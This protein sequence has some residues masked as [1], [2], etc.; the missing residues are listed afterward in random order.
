[1]SRA[2]LPVI[3]VFS[4]LLMLSASIQAQSLLYLDINESD[5]GS[6]APGGVFFLWDPEFLEFW[7][8][9]SSGTV[10]TQLWQNGAVA[11]FGAGSDCWGVQTEIASNFSPPT[12]GGIR[13][14]DC[15]VTISNNR[16]VLVGSSN[17]LYT[18][19]SRELDVRSQ[20]DWPPNGAIRKT[21]PGLLEFTGATGDGGTSLSTNFDLEEGTLRLASS[22]STNWFGGESSADLSI[23]TGSTSASLNLGSADQL[24]NSTVIDLIDGTF[25]LQGNDETIRGLTGSGLVT[26]GGIL[27]ISTNPSTYAF[28]G[29]ITD[30]ATPTNLTI[31]GAGEQRFNGVLSHSGGTNV[32]G[33]GR[34]AVAGS[35]TTSAIVVEDGELASFNA[36]LQDV[37]ILPSGTLK[38]GIG[39]TTA[40]GLSWEDGG[41]VAWELGPTATNSDSSNLVVTDL[42]SISDGSLT[43]RINATSDVPPLAQSY[44]LILFSS[45]NNTTASHYTVDDGGLLDGRDVSIRIESD[46]VWLD[47]GALDNVFEDRFETLP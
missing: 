33:G 34:L 25:T 38:L 16:L 45:G 20:L 35:L 7:S 14:E 10:A 36:E 47:I 43:I 6:G 2:C 29:S 28:D 3:V 9:S 11:V 37:T 13:L 32:E 17:E 30:G 24:R 5:P 18:A 8:T 39:S 19:G 40:D 41:T 31:A 21:G 1:M 44:P 46:T 27:T 15:D 22:S 42:N 26:G 23:G 12:I 4:T